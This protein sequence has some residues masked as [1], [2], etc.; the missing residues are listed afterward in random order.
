MKLDYEM[1]ILLCIYWN[2]NRVCCLWLNNSSKFTN[3]KNVEWTSFVKAMHGDPQMWKTVNSEKM[4]VLT[5]YYFWN[6]QIHQPLF[7]CTVY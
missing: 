3:N 7:E 6:K 4:Q 2:K 1:K 5:L